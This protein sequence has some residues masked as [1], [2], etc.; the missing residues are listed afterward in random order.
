MTQAAWVSLRSL[1]ATP[2]EIETGLDLE[3]V[4][5]T[6]VVVASS[7]ETL[8]CQGSSRK[9]LTPKVGFR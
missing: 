2:L 1:P 9:K 3:F 5:A 4:P 8:D 7:T 6:R